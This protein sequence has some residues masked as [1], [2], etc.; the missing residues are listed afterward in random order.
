MAHKRPKEKEKN[1]ETNHMILIVT[2]RN[3]W[4]STLHHSHSHIV[5]SAWDGEEQEEAKGSQAYFNRILA[6]GFASV[7]R[8]KFILIHT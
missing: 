7:G 1:M 5:H 6:H 2:D 4:I 3:K 8:I